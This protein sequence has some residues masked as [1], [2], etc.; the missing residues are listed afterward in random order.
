MSLNV[1]FPLVFKTDHSV[2][3]ENLHL[4]LHLYG[5]ALFTMGYPLDVIIYSLF[6]I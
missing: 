6:N 1:K 5:T 4:S 3:I 2:L